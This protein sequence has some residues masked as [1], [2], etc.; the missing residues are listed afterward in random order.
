MN[1]RWLN[2]VPAPGVA[3]AVAGVMIVLYGV[4]KSL[5]S[6]ESREV[7]AEAR[8]LFEAGQKLM[9]AGKADAAVN[10]FERA[11]ALD[12][13]NRDFELALASAQLTAGKADDAEQT[14]MEVLDRDSND[15]RAN[16]LMARVRVAQNR[17]DNAVSYYHRAIYGSWADGSGAERTEARLELAEQLAKRGR[18]QELLSE[19]L[20]LDSTARKTPQL[21]KKLAAL[22]LEAGS[23]ARAEAA[24]RAMVRANRMDAEAYEG[25]GQAEL[26][27]GEYRAAHSAFASALKYRPDDPKAAKRM[28]LA[29]RLADLD[30][31]SRRLGSVEKFKRSQEILYLTEDAAMDCMKGRELPGALHD[32]LAISQKMRMEKMSGMPSNEAAEAR[33]EL[34]G[35]IWKARL[36]AC[37]TEPSEEDPLTIIIRKVEQ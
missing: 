33:L 15:G 8:G 26:R 36:Q 37:P 3:L 21:D 11:H 10:D 1:W 13:T 2:R 32:L 22:Y 9:S 29:D 4:D 27:L 17:F 12:R 35:Q 25:L 23:A 31:T 28:Q 5:A 7:N 24:Y 14:V 30:P 20:L 34:A 16:Y 18:N 19:L 6:L